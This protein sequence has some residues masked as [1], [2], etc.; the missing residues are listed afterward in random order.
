MPVL[1]ILLVLLMA[2]LVFVPQWWVKHVLSQ[3]QAE[4]DDLGGTGAELARLLLDKADLR[5]VK[6]E[7]TEGGDHYDPTEE[8][9]RLSLPHHDGKSIAALAVAA[10]EVGHALQHAEGDRMFALRGALAPRII[11]IE[12]TAQIVFFSI[13]LLGVL[14][15][16]PALIAVQI[17]LIVALMG[18]RLAM[19]LVTLPIEL[20]ASFKRALP[21][22]EAGKFVPE[23]DRP[24]AR[25]VLTAAA[26][27]Y[28]AAALLT[29]VDVT[30]FIRILR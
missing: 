26:Y 2:A 1:I 22:L 11:W 8:T 25:R 13:P 6:V 16:S 21:I 9:V 14:A 19:H 15:R 12:R 18:A 28:V 10:H 3:N 29:L 24:A 23:Q 20:D 5:H 30:R 7:L 27:T 4:R 17:V